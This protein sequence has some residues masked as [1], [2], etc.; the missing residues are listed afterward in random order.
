MKISERYALGQWL[1]DYPEN[2]TYTEI[3]ETLA[4][5]PNDWTHEDFE[6]WDVVETYPLAQVAHFI[7]DTREMIEKAIAETLE[8]KQ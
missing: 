5:L 1:C 8:V 2:K 4:A 3:I 6:L 7:E